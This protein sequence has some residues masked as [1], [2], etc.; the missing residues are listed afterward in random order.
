MAQIIRE[1]F[2][3]TYYPGHVRRLPKQLG[4]SVQRLGLATAEQ[5]AEVS[6]FGGKA[7][8]EL[9]VFLEARTITT[10]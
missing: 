2:D 3:R 10:T 1:A 4:Y 6:R 9:K 8:A 5:I 7:A